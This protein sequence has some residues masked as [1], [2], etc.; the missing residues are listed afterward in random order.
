MVMFQN[1]LLPKSAAARKASGSIV[2]SGGYAFLF[3]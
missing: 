2:L 3:I 1:G